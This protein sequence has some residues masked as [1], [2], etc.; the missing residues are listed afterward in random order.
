MAIV[1]ILLYKYTTI[2]VLKQMKRKNYKILLWINVFFVS[3]CVDK[4]K[5]GDS[6]HLSPA[7]KRP[8][9]LF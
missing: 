9:L 6:I 5:A 3:F 8:W 1:F 4:K 7:G 2:F